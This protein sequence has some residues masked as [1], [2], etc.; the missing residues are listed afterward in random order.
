MGALSLL[1]R[2]RKPAAAPLPG[3]LG[4]AAPS[5]SPR[6]RVAM[7]VAG[8]VLAHIVLALL[9]FD[10]TPHTG[11]DNAAYITLAR[12]LLEHGAYLELYDPATPPHTQ[13]PPVFP[14]M[15]AL[16]LLVGLRPWIG[17]KL[18]I[19]ACSA[20][21]VAFSYLWLRR[22]RRPELALRVGVLL[23]VSPGVL[24]LSHWV[25]SDVPFWLLTLMALWAFERLPPGRRGRFAFAIAA[26]VLAYFT[27]S[28]GLPLVLAAAGWFALRRRWREL[29]V[30]ALAFV[31]LALVWWLRARAAGGVDY[32]DQFW[33]VNPYRPD[34]GRIGAL[35]LFE[36]VIDNDARYLKRHLPI[37][38]WGFEGTAAFVL[39]IILVVLAVFGWV[40]RLRRPAVAELFLAL[41]V[42]LLFVWPA[43]W[44]GE[45]FLLPVLPLLL[46]YAGESV[47]RI[48][49]WWRRAAAPRVAI[50]AGLVTLAL[51]LPALAAGMRLGFTCTQRYLRGDTYPCLSRE[52]ADLFT[53][54][55]WSRTNL[56]DD[57]AVLSRKP[58][59]FYVLSGHPGRNFP[60]SRE[61]DDFFRA[62]L[63]ARARY[64]VYDHVDD[65]ADLYLGP[66]LLR[67][68]DAF[69][70]MRSL[71]IE[72][73]VLLGIRADAAWLRNERG[74][75]G[76]TEQV[77]DMPRCPDEYWRR[78]QGSE[79][80]GG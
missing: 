66:V 21:A 70:V 35:D 31:P 43:V 19:V 65:L 13:Y 1:G 40:E 14:G 9:F 27:R 22:R 79:P 16:A 36:R 60:L 39:S 41:Y 2:R 72:G 7:I 53:L 28:A 58:R 78:A 68:P 48:A 71:G 32:V 42:G 23:A 8:L 80:G 26:T 10:P 33:M 15:L 5:R 25:L 61:P 34:L 74:D 54:A 49:G 17:L 73:A 6:V 77:L 75:P 55:E 63:D 56:P 30:L 45:R 18:L 20:A 51:M 12:S 37:L 4:P 76:A 46:A 67:R 62:A 38:L 69:C 50:A 3:E 44:S 47:L 24:D 52:W 11:G 59:L 57:A 29:G 64:V